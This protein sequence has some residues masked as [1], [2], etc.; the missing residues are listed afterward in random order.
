MT[1]EDM[2]R[3]LESRHDIQ[4]VAD[5]ARLSGDAAYQGAIAAS[6]D[7]LAAAR[8]VL[9]DKVAH[10]T[11]EASET[12]AERA[13]VQKE[14]GSALDHYRYYRSR[15]Y[16]ALL[17]PPPGMQPSVEESVRRQRMY[18]RYYKLSASDLGR[19]ALEKQVE[20]LDNLLTAH[21]TEEELKNLGHTAQL[22]AAFRPAI[23]AVQEF[24]RETREDLMATAVLVE[25]RATFDRAHK[26]HTLLIDS[27]LVRY[28]LESEA[29]HF[30]KRRD[31]TYAAR[32]NAKAPVAQEPEAVSIETEIQQ[33]EPVEEVAPA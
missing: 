13:N 18:E 21:E 3:L 24:H 4:A 7:E 28:G 20:V 25:A 6:R 9:V 30:I 16:D 32:R 23:A 10:N 27:F 15:T 12:D 19:Q 22:E 31:P 29:G 33:N 2:I 5:P 11:Q 17:N 8:A 1:E 26:A 14:L